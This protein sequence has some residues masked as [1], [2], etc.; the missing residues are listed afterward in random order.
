MEDETTLNLILTDAGLAEVV[1]A[2]NNGTAPVLLT[3]IALGEGRTATATQK[4]LTSEFKRLT[5]VSGGNIGDNIIHISATDADYESYTAYEVGIF[6]SS[7]TLFAVCA[8]SSPIIE[9]ALKSNAI[10]AFDIVL[11][12]V[13]PAYVTVGDTNFL[14]NSAT[15]EKE[16]IIELATEAE[17]KAGTDT[18]RAVT[19]KALDA[20]IEAHDNIVHK[21]GAEAI[22]GYKS[23]E[24][25][26]SK[27]DVT[28][29]VSATPTENRYSSFDFSDKNNV[30]YA[31]VVGAIY[32]TDEVG[33]ILATNRTINGTEYHSQISVRLDK[34]GSPYATAPTPA[35]GDNSTKIATTSWVT[36]KAKEYLP[37]AGGTMTGTLSLQN[38]ATEFRDTQNALSP[39][40]NTWHKGKISFCDKNNTQVGFIQPMF[41]TDGSVEFRFVASDPTNGNKYFK[42]RSN[43]AL[44]WDGKSI[45]RSVNGANANAAGDVTITSVSGNAGTATKLQTARTITLGGD[46]SG[47]TTFDGSGN[48]TITATVNDDSHNHTIANVD[49]LQSA[50]DGKAASSHT[51]SY[52]PLSGGQMTSTTAI[53]RNVAN[54]FLGLHGGTGTNNDGA[55]L[56]LCGASHSTMPGAFQLTARNSS[57]AMTLQGDLD[58]VLTW[59]DKYVLNNSFLMPT[60]GGAIHLTAGTSATGGAYFRLYGKD[61]STG[62]GQFSIAATD[63]TNTKALVG[64]PDGSLTWMGKS[65]LTEETGIVVVETWKSSDGLSW[66][67][68]WSDG[69]IEQ[70]G[71]TS[72]QDTKTL[73]TAFTTTKYNV[74]GTFN[75]GDRVLAIEEKTTTTFYARIYNT[76][77]KNGYDGTF[78][79]YACGF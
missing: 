18:H 16:G 56:F 72:G 34:N 33:A 63:G 6:T 40:A 28:V 4:A 51:H 32:S 74:Q 67:R 13:N 17:A 20:T 29:S 12:N 39:T 49:G 57:K 42:L 75:T 41:M 54:S 73:P 60:N 15:T 44:E 27:R 65:L 47:S 31:S 62:A 55:Q 52:L 61:H 35:A 9:K 2:E 11:S 77:G 25:G 64:K 59:N 19:P 45:V 23:F 10:I 24:G 79:W 30:K 5:A 8:Q 22:T 76:D 50:L 3:E 1:N 37:L 36:A 69:W 43:G 66:Y 53:S 70:G 68:K 14:L 78:D 71:T 58:G 48:V 26:V 46:L 21:K 7:G 38:N